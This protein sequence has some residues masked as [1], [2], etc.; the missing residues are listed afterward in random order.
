MPGIV[1][2]SRAIWLIKQRLYV[3]QTKILS[4]IKK[5]TESFLTFCNLEVSILVVQLTLTI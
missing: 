5:K 3:R 4:Q 2:G 1:R